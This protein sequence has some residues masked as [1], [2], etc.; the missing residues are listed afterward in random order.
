MFQFDRKRQNKA[1]LFQIFLKTTKWTIGCFDNSIGWNFIALE[2]TL[3]LKEIK[4]HV[5]LNQYME[6]INKSKTTR[7]HTQTHSSRVFKLFTQIWRHQNILFNNNNIR[8]LFREKL[9]RIIKN[10][11]RKV[12]VKCTEAQGKSEGLVIVVSS[13]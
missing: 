9:K 12:R 1:K 5:S 8:C 10:D 2:K 13:H 11:N 7:Q 3:L 4:N 6:W